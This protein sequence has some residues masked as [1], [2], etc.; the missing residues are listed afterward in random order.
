MKTERRLDARN[1]EVEH[2]T[3]S[4]VDGKEIVH[5]FTITVSHDP[6][7]PRGCYEEV[8]FSGRGKIGAGLDLLFID[9]GVWVSRILQGRDPATGEELGEDVVSRPARYRHVATGGFYRLVGE[10]LRESDLAKLAVYRSEE[11]GQVWTRPWEE[12]HD[13]RFELIFEDHK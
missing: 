9:V 4:I 3:G 12:F 1:F 7:D 8:A 13:G 2:H 6:K 5:C 10:A 11:T